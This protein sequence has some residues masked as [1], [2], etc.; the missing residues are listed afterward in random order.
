MN[1]SEKERKTKKVV[2][3]LTRNAAEIETNLEALGFAARVVEANRLKAFDE[4]L[5]EVA[6]GTDLNMLEK[7]DRILALALKSPTGGIHW[8]IPVPGTNYIGLRIARRSREKSHEEL[9]SLN[10]RDWRSKLA[11]GFY[12]IGEA[13]FAIGRKILGY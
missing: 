11:S 8:Q 7:H 5:L 3:D 12:S 13:S 2:D 1:I 9:M 4:F 10:R 6:L